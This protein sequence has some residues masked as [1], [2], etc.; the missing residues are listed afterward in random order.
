MDEIE[1]LRVKASKSDAVR[2]VADRLGK[3]K[4]E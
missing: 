4:E 2:T 1:G 3:E